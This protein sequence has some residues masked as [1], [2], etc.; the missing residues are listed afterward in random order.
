MRAIT[1]LTR[2]FA[3]AALLCAA[4]AAAISPRGKRAALLGDSMTWIGGS[5]CDRPCGWTATFREE[6]GCSAIDVY[7]RS[8]ATWTNTAATRV[9]TEFYSELLHDDN[10]VFNQ[11]QRLINAV[12]A[13]S[14]LRPD[15]I[16]LY[17]GANDAWFASR[18]PG[19]FNCE[20][21]YVA[22]DDAPS[23]A[24]TLAGSVTLVC[25]RLN[26]AFPDATLLLVTPVEMA[27]A[28]AARTARV[29]EI[30]DSVGRSMDVAVVRADTLSGISRLNELREPRRHTTDGAHTN[31]AG[32]VAISRCI[33]SAL[34]AATPHCSQK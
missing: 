32:A 9:D 1:H 33:L 4:S 12:H 25:S 13:D 29:A 17:A 22:P 3:A 30:I 31:A 5:D 8:G 16:I 18:R 26:R 19:L 6:A 2:I 15:I 14:L 21:S 34:R 10:V 7:A 23:S 11:A 28:P 24:T 27:Q 20:E